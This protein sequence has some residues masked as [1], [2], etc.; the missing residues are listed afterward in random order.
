MATRSHRAPRSRSMRLRAILTLGVF[1]LPL[2]MGTLA[3][4]TDSV[5][6]TGAT[7]TG[8]TLDLS[9]SGGDP[10]AS[11]S[12][13]M[14]TAVPGSTSAEVL[15]VQNVGNV[16]LKFSLTGGVS[17]GAAAEMAPY[18]NL[19]IRQGGTKSGTTC[20]NG[21]EIYNAALTTDTATNFIAPA[22]AHQLD[23]TTGTTTESLCFQVTFGAGA[24]SSL[25]GSSTTATI[26]FL[27]TTY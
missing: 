8:G 17:G 6:V 4:W 15:T 16:P 26:T 23:A 5:S 9:V 19:S 1:A 13:A 20:I 25:Q 2:G 11:A 10:V 18:L 7:F 27:G 21:T 12:L 3:F 14:S 24:P 22:S